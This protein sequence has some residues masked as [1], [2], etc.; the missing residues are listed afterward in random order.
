MHIDS[1]LVAAVVA[2]ALSSMTARASADPIQLIGTGRVAGTASDGLSFADPW[3]ED[4]VTPRDQIGGFGSAIAYT[5]VGN[6]FLAAPDRGPA[7]GATSYPD[8]YYLFE[9]A[10]DPAAAEPVTVSLKRAELLTDEAGQQLTGS[11]AAFDTGRRFDAEGVRLDGHGGFYV[12]DEYG[13]FLYHFDAS[14]RR[15]GVVPLPAAFGTATPSADP[16]GELPPTITRGRQPNRGMEGLAIS[17]DGKKLFGMM[18]NALIQDGA[19]DAENARI[20][21]NN[22]ILEIDTTTGQT[23]QYV[24]ELEGKKYGVNEIVAI[25]DHRLLVLERDS[26]GGEE[27]KFKQIFQIDIS[28]A[29]DVSAIAALPTEGLPEAV[30]AV[31]KKPFLDLLDPAFGLVGADFPEKIEGLAFGPRLA[32]GRLT[33]IVSVDNDFVVE[34]DSLLWAFAIAPD[35][36]ELTPQRY[37]LKV[38]RFAHAGDYGVVTF[39]GQALLPVSAIDRG[40]LRLG[41]AAPVGLGDEPFCFERDFDRDGIRDLACIFDAA[42]VSDGAKLDASTTSGSPLDGRL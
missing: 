11:V 28:A 10:I 37:T 1:K 15:T 18:Q 36:L 24:Y 27:A 16:D 14:G 3:L 34:N 26:N 7:D 29:S 30:T 6:R 12:S 31:A 23:R 4:G 32:D 38:A 13:P 8:R 42:A 33:L 5:G 40:S 20:G 22:R 41:G 2:A 19:L 35:Q 39:A 17:P 9:I 25:D 21:L